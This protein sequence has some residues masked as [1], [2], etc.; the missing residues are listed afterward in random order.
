MVVRIKHVRSQV[1]TAVTA[2]VAVPTVVENT[3]TEGHCYAQSADVV[4]LG[5]GV[6]LIIAIAAEFFPTRLD[7]LAHVPNVNPQGEC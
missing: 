6:I 2:L 7:T 5:L 4:N 3:G 1:P